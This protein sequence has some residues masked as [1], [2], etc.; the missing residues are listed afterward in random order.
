M[1]SWRRW[2]RDPSPHVVVSRHR[3]GWRNVSPPRRRKPASP[4]HWTTPHLWLSSHESIVST[5]V[6]VVVTRKVTSSPRRAKSISSP[7]RWWGR[8]STTPTHHM[9]P[10]L[11]PSPSIVLVKRL[12]LKPSATRSIR[13]SSVMVHALI[14]GWGL[15]PPGMPIGVAIV[16]IFVRKRYLAC[17]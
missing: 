9:P 12:V 5:V 6:A 2:R 4:H 1:I 16:H 8:W 10:T 14:V 17:A 11:K 3:W 13:H 15:M 7:P